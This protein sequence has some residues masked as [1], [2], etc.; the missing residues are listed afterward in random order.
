MFW[1]KVISNLELS[2]W[3]IGYT[4]NIFHILSLGCFSPFLGRMKGNFTK[5]IRDEK[6]LLRVQKII[7]FINAEKK[8]SYNKT[9]EEGKVLVLRKMTIILKPFYCI[10]NVETRLHGSG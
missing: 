9:T 3:H 4:T 5:L 8:G 7:C 6:T 1:W 10:I 2:E